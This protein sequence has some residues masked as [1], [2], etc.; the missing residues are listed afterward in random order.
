MKCFYKSSI[1]GREWSVIDR[2][3]KKVYM[4]VVQN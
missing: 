1:D 4:S 3:I 2:N